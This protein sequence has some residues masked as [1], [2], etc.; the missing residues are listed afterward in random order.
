MSRGRLF[1]VVLQR[2]DSKPDKSTWLEMARG[3]AAAGWQVEILTSYNRQPYVV[4]EP[5][6]RVRC[7]PRLNA[8]GLFRASALVSIGAWLWRNG[9]P[10]DLVIV[11]ADGLWLVPP[12]AL[13]G[14]RD[15][16]LDIRTVPVEVHGLKR[17]LDRQLWW[18]LPMRLF[19]HRV[20]GH[21]FITARLRDSVHHEFDTRSAHDVIWESGVNVARFHAPASAAQPSRKTTLF[22][23]GTLSPNRGLDRLLEGL[24]QLQ[25]D[26]IQ[27]VRLVMVGD[28]PDAARLRQLAAD[29]DLSEVV[30]FRGLVPYEDVPRH[31][32]EADCC[33]CPLPGR[34]EWD[35]SSPLKMFEYMAAGKPMIL[36]PIAAHLD[37]LEGRPF[38]VWA[39]GA[40]AGDFAA[41]IRDYL[42]SRDRLQRVA[43][44][45]GPA[46]AAAHDWRQLARRF[47]NY[48]EAA[49]GR[50]T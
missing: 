23:H 31:L 19:A 47:A 11:S 40:E 34:P 27:D 24:A 16:H 26:E 38:V 21:S 13:R 44:V 9:S 10:E 50:A 32:A 12:L 29:L 7:L 2:F 5:D 37:V 6:F 4:D 17:R 1:W 35:V 8:G 30:E 41:A 36:T 39:R 15:I 25:P 45:D 48:L 46:S 22:Y 49:F 42:S 33:I 20:R 14:L 18:R 3:L 43:A 28:G